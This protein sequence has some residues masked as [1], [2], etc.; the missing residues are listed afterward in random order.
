MKDCP[1]YKV[2]PEG[3]CLDCKAYVLPVRNSKTTRGDGGS[4]NYYKLPPNATELRHLIRYKNMGHSIGE[5]FCALYRLND[6]GEYERNLK[7]AL[8]YI[9]SELEEHNMY[10]DKNETTSTS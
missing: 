5:A 7:K 9:Q 3:Y 6:N 10:G 1:H 8:F 4:T 2:T